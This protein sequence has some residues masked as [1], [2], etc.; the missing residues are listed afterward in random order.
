MVFKIKLLVSNIFIFSD[1]KPSFSPSDYPTSDSFENS[2]FSFRGFNPSLTHVRTPHGREGGARRDV[3]GLSEKIFLIL[4]TF[5]INTK[6][7]SLLVHV[8]F[9]NAI[10]TRAHTLLFVSTIITNDICSINH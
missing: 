6:I 10:A 1:L 7:P 5:N 9:H 3:I 4:C 2:T 8:L